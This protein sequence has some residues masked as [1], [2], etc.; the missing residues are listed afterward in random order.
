MAC[1]PLFQTL[2][3]LFQSLDPLL[4]YLKEN[5]AVLEA[6]LEHQL[7]PMILE[8]IWTT[9]LTAVQ[10]TLLVGVSTLLVGL[11]LLVGSEHA[12]VRF[13][14]LSVCLRAAMPRLLPATAASRGGG[15]RLSLQRHV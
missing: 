2:D 5:L 15:A 13:D 9:V 4:T 7:Y 6:K 12:R 8:K 14:V 3:P 11:T 10:K 1:G